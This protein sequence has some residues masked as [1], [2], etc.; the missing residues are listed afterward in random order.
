MS[1]LSLTSITQFRL[2]TFLAN[3]YRRESQRLTIGAE[4]KENQKKSRSCSCGRANKKKKKR[5]QSKQNGKLGKRV[6]LVCHW[7][8]PQKLSKFQHILLKI[9][10][11]KNKKYA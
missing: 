9:G 4:N 11:G 10:Y 1:F 2:S 8:G 5:N 6:N 3:F 7:Y